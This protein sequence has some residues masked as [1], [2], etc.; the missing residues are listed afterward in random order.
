M[1]DRNA[2]K[3][4]DK[5]AQTQA[6]ADKAK[7]K[8]KAAADSLSKYGNV[9][10]SGTVRSTN[11][12]IYS[13]GFVSHGMVFTSPTPVKLLGISSNL[14]TKKKNIVGRGAGMMITGGLSLLNSNNKGMVYITL[15]TS[16]GSK[17]FKSQS[18]TNTDI[19]SIMKLEAAGR[20]VLESHISN[21]LTAS[22]P[23]SSLADELAKLAELK[24]SGA[25][26][27]AEYTAAKKKL[28]G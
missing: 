18:P 21:N 3:G 2:G 1:S 23:E 12:T 20:A 6:K 16:Q 15:V 8:A 19:S 11:I 28:L 5:S 14:N 10:A 25:L 13:K 4:A 22:Q 24:K 9:I 7:A 17:T 26:T 27:A